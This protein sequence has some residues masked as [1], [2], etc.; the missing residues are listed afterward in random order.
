MTSGSS[1]PH[2]DVE[3]IRR[4]L[5]HQLSQLHALL[6]ALSS[7]GDDPYAFVVETYTRDKVEAA[8]QQ[9]LRGCLLPQEYAECD[10]CGRSLSSGERVRLRGRRSVETLVWYLDEVACEACDLSLRPEKEGMGVLA[11]VQLCDTDDG[12]LRVSAVDVYESIGVN[13]RSEGTQPAETEGPDN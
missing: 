6:E 1:Q 5:S 11:T 9:A 4:K 3:L 2:A 10:R 12:D 8:A 7:G 13:Y